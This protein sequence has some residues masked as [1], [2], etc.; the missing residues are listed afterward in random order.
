MTPD[1]FNHG[2]LVYPPA[3]FNRP[4]PQWQRPS[5]ASTI[6]LIVK[7]G[8]YMA[9][10]RNPV[11]DGDSQNLIL[12]YTEQPGKETTGHPW[13]LNKRILDDDLQLSARMH[14]WIQRL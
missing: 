3:S 4:Y 2:S 13:P 8:C 9:Y 14:N 12:C 5:T 11:R 6:L 1:S 7:F 10:L